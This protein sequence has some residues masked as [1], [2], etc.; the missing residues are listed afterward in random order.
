MSR[1]KFLG[2]ASCA[3]LGS[4]TMLSS[5][6][7]LGMLNSLA[8]MSLPTY[9]EDNTYKAMI[10][11]LLAGGSDSFNLLVPRSANH[12][13][14]YATTRSN[15]ALPQNDLLPINFTDTIG[16]QFGVHPSMPEVQSMFNNNK[17][18]FVANVG[19]L[20]EPTTKAQYL[21]Q[22]VT[23]PLGLFSHADQ[24]QQWQTSIP[25]T[26]SSVGWGGKIAD[27]LHAGNGNQN[28]S[29][30][31]TLSGTNLFQIGNNITEYAI[32]AS[33]GGSVGIN[34]YDNTDPVS[35]YLKTNVEN[36]LNQQYA[37][38]FRS[39]YGDKIANSQ[40]YHEQFNAALA[41]AP[42]LNTTFS[43]SYLS[44]NMALIAKTISVRNTLNVNRQTFFVTYGGWD[45]HDNLLTNQIDMLGVLSTALGELEAALQEIGVFNDVTT[46]TVSDFARTL[47]S[48][49]NGSDHAW[50]GNTMVLGGGVNGG[51]VYG[52]YPSLAY[53]GVDDVGNGIML[54]TTSTDE[55]FAELAEW[56]GISA[57]DLPYV[58]PNVGNFY[59]PGT[60]GAIGFMNI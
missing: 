26:R 21:N 31:I 23:V 18:A 38:I 9:K 44:Q 39:T 27:I 56:F 46:F 29:M 20:V 60:G 57:T 53:N 1:R 24:I 51:S 33:A 49:G 59:T 43:N 3:A 11:I 54:P 36:L 40:S 58:L 16:R 8:G 50:G 55:Y 34:V 45:H 25:Q 47:T 37:D 30:N 7:N 5:I 41:N 32:R 48:N 17:L 13:L 14:E 42:T 19:T 15:L 2:T 22:G 12:Y 10:C 6:L 35:Q 52:T 28:I 4:T